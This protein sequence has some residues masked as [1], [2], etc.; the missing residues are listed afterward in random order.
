MFKFLLVFCIVAL[1]VTAEVLV[2]DAPPPPPARDDDFAQRKLQS[3]TSGGSG[4]C[5]SRGAGTYPYVPN[6]AVALSFTYIPSGSTTSKTITTSLYG[7]EFQSARCGYNW[8]VTTNSQQ[9]DYSPLVNPGMGLITFSQCSMASERSYLQCVQSSGYGNV[10]STYGQDGQTCMP[11][12]G[13][14]S[15]V[16]NTQ[17]YCSQRSAYQAFCCYCPDGKYAPTGSV[18]VGE[19]NCASCPPGSFMGYNLQQSTSG[20]SCFPC[21]AGT[22]QDTSGATTDCTAC[23]AGKSTFTQNQYTSSGNTYSFVVGATS[24]DQC[25]A[26]DKMVCTAPPCSYLAKDM[27]S[28]T[29]NGLDYAPGGYSYA[30]RYLSACPNFGYV[31][32][33]A[34]TASLVCTDPGAS[35]SCTGNQNSKETDCQVCPGTQPYFYAG[36]QSY[37]RQ[38]N[39]Y[40]TGFSSQLS[41]YVYGTQMFSSQK[42]TTSE[43]GTIYCKFAAF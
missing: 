7:Y 39:N 25:V 3:P 6:A 37:S 27:I 8:M 15:T 26:V 43:G 19:S 29:V 22:Y 33:A 4:T 34:S 17:S 41:Q 18:M 21:P 36:G 23:P 2:A 42:V 11:T 16:F 10:G 20:Q 5:S 12:S 31:L 32:A 1:G 14:G 30:F 40:Y 24:V 28:T 9:A 35:S 38:I 13:S